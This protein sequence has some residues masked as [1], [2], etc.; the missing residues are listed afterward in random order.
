MPAPGVPTPGTEERTSGDA[1]D[2]AEEVVH[3]A[4]D[5]AT[6][7]AEVADG[8]AED[9][10]AVAT[11]GERAADGGTVMVED[12]GATDDG[13]LPVSGAAAVAGPPRIGTGAA[14]SGDGVV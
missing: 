3:A 7:G 11:L 6:G 2:G 8:T 13:P 10:A 9:I 14:S 4:G 1:E 5:D 12:G